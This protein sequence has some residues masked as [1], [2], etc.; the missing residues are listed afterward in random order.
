[1]KYSLNNVQFSILND[2]IGF[3]IVFLL[4]NQYDLLTQMTILNLT[5]E[6]LTFDF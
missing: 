2:S 4:S 1:M 5:I 6:F 3:R